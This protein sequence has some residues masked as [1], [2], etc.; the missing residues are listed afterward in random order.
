L[1]QNQKQKKMNENSAIFQMF[2]T[3]AESANEAI[4]ITSFPLK[5]NN[6]I[7]IIYCNNA[8]IDFYKIDREI[9]E[10]KNV[11][12]ILNIQNEEEINKLQNIIYSTASEK[13]IDLFVG[14]HSNQKFWINFSI[15]S[16]IENE[17]QFNIWRQNNYTI[18]NEIKYGEISIENKINNIQLKVEDSVD[19]IYFVDFKG[20]LIYANNVLLRLLEYT[21][22]ELLNIGILSVH[23]NESS[24]AAIEAF[25][26][27][28][29]GE[30]QQYDI[31]LKSKS[32]NLLNFTIS[33]F[34]Y[35][36]NDKIEGVFYN[37]KETTKNEISTRAENLSSQIKN[38]FYNGHNFLQNLNEVVRILSNETGYE[39]VE[40][41]LPDKLFTKSNLVAYHYPKTSAF[42]EFYSVSSSLQLNLNEDD[43]LH[44]KNGNEISRKVINLFMNDNFPR[45]NWVL[46]LGITEGLSFPM[47]LEDKLVASFTFFSR[48]K[49]S[50]FNATTQLI[51]IVSNKIALSI[52]YFVQRNEL[53]QIFNLSPDFLC[54]LDINGKIINANNTFTD[55]LILNKEEI[56]G[57]PFV[58]FVEDKN[59]D[60]INEK[61]LQLKINKLVRL[62][63]EFINPL[64]PLKKLSLEWSFS[65]DEDGATIYGAAKDVT[66]KKEFE[67]KLKEI[68]DR[69]I[70]LSKATNDVIYEWDI[71]TDTIHW[72]ESFTKI[73]G[74]QL[75]DLTSNHEYWSSFVHP[76]D[77]K[78]LK[79]NFDSAKM[80][81]S[82]NLVNEY[83]F[84]DLEGNYRN[85]LDRGILIYNEN[86]ELIKMVGAMQDITLLKDSEVSLENL[87]NVL[88]QRA[89]QLQNL[90]KELEQ[91]AYI[92]SHDLQEPLRMISSFMKLLL[93][94]NESTKTEKSELYIN[95]AID[96]ANRMKRL[97]NDL[98]TYSRVGA[99]EEDFIEIDCN[100]ILKET[101]QVYNQRII[102][103][104]AKINVNPLPKIKA[105]HSLIG[106][107]FDNLISN[108]LKYNDKPI[109]TVDIYF[110]EN[111]THYII[112]FKDNGIGIDSRYIDL[113]SMPFKRLHKMNEY[114]GTGIGLAVVKKIAEKHNGLFWLESQLNIG[115]TFYISFKK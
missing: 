26:A 89:R 20:K 84:L 39:C 47:Y 74:H 7:K 75:I 18:N 79:G 83:R 61:L 31:V 62:E 53:N 49:I 46:N 113:V 72:N 70:L 107:V 98:L 51:K 114:S 56:L 115:S 5:E 112:Q 86:N 15:K 91:F 9:I 50:N 58:S 40:C 110:E 38:I 90:N 12:D 76:T 36:I 81:Y 71:I 88:Q 37:G 13:E 32:G 80:K 55:N 42:D 35:F 96:G 3:I 52:K 105:I 2:T 28:R 82:T 77:Q 43:V 59:Y 103:T 44:T 111:P 100:F 68:N 10:N 17:V 101:L 54:M 85:I 27:T 65:L 16:F 87:N 104:G 48:T 23:Y 41:W 34:P 30:H 64:Y 25:F 92:V 78:R 63:T 57:K 102:E 69:Y 33:S 94:E 109:P 106:Q 21:E 1:V 95:F 66:Q 60:Y 93:S 22:Q 67:E 6:L 73:F 4:V 14:V 24:D 99:T 97:I 45:K 19:P 8:F 108:A 11:F 29:Q